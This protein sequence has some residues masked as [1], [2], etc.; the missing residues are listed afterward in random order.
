MLL[1]ALLTCGIQSLPRVWPLPGKSMAFLRSTRHSWASR[2]STSGRLL[3]LST[4]ASLTIII[5][6]SM[7]ILTVLCNLSLGFH[8]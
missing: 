5:F 6:L 2:F 7:E 3:V 4:S 1:S 8:F